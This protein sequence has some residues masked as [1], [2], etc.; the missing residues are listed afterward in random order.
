MNRTSV[1]LGAASVAGALLL[2]PTAAQAHVSVSSPDAAREGF[3][4]VVFRVPTEPDTASTTK[5]E[6]DL[7]REQPFAFVSTQ[8]K[9]GWKVK[10]TKSKLPKP[11]KTEYATISEAVSKVTWTATGD[12]IA[13]GEFDEFAVSAG[14]LPDVESVSFAA[15]Q[16]YSD[17]EVVDWDEKQ[18]GDEEP[19]H[20]A[21]VLALAAAS[22]DHHGGASGADDKDTSGV[23][24]AFDSSDKTARITAAVAVVVAVVSLAFAVR[25]NRRRA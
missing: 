5:V 14:P 21:P 22:E 3:G 8:V 16:T 10:I 24:Y 19:E 18:T 20:P 13:P 11:V 23:S 2:I 4:K 15:R 25:E 9:P 17:G 7:P 6:I 12:G 1:R